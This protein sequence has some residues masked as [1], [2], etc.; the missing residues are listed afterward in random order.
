MSGG[1]LPTV[2]TGQAISAPAANM[3]GG[4]PL[5]A[6][7]MP[8]W[9]QGLMAA[10]TGNPQ[11]GQNAPQINGLV[12]S[13]LGGAMGQQQPQG[14]AGQMMR[15]PMMQGGAPPVGAG[16]PGAVPG[17]GQPMP[18]VQPPWMNQ[19]QGAQQPQMSPQM[20]QMIMQ[21]MQQGG[22]GMGGGM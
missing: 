4:Q 12:K 8:S 21:R 2:G 18:Q 17:T 15:R 7:P 6:Q 5:T 20:M 3:P 19:Q 1:S 16:A 10:T 9:M 11:Y 14:G 22:G 13:A